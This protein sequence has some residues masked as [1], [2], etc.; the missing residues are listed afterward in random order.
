MFVSTAA[1]RPAET[2]S[3]GAEP[4]DPALVKLALVVVV[5]VAAAILDL[6]I[7]TV[8]I[9]TMQ[10][11]LDAGVATIQ[12]VSTG[13]ALAVALT[14]PVSGWL[15]Q[16]LGA[17]RAWLLAL[18]IFGAGSALCAAAW[19]VESLIAFRVLQGVGGGLLLPLSQMIL[20]HAAGRERLARVVPYVAIPSQLGPVLGPVVGGIVL[21]SADWRWIFLINIPVL[22]V[23]VLLARRFVPDTTTDQERR[24]DVLGLALLSPALGL[25]VFGFSQA[26]VA[27]RFDRPTVIAPL[28]AGVV[29]LAGYC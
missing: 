22:V 24:L 4:L 6:T 17:R 12:W 20:L 7:V 25:L 23:A 15:F 3:T 16:R 18:T 26:G 28:L 13:Y 19:S 29:L 5:G 9:D 10:R 27:G 21:G 11:R 2:G 8:A 14:I 1:D